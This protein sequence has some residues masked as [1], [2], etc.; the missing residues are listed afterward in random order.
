MLRDPPVVFLL[1]VADS[2]DTV[3]RADGELGLGR[4]PTD[5]GS[6]TVDAEKDQGGLVSLGGR[7]PDEGVAIW[8]CVSAQ[9][10]KVVRK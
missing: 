6:C 5:K 10:V 3:A 9:G 2:D 8:R 4:R 1:E 7:F